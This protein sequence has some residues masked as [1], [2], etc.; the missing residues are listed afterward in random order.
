MPHIDFPDVEAD[1]AGKDDED[2]G[3]PEDEP[4][5]VPSDFSTSERKDLGLEALAVFERR[6]RLGH[7]YDLLNAVKMSVNHQ[8][9]VRR[10]R[11]DASAGWLVQ[12][13]PRPSARLVH[14]AT[15][16]ILKPIN[17]EQ[18]LKSKNWRKPRE[19]GD[20]R[21]EQ[22]W[23]WT[24]IPPWTS[25]TDADAWQLE[26]VPSS[27]DLARINEEINKLHAE[28]KRTILG[29]KNLSLAWE[30]AALKTQ[31]SDGSRAY[32]RKK[33]D[34]FQKLSDQCS[35]TFAK[36]RRDPERSGITPILR[37]WGFGDP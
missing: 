25:K 1:E 34:M 24:A 37:K 8:A 15:S 10:R 9:G 23:I 3:S 2:C 21:E 19:Q 13:Q 12:L 14:T 36:A 31:L 30:S 4:L 11:T 29:F 5:V 35:E 22:S 27:A 33:A 17:M 18:D 6:I 28:F 7:A 20:S 32:A 26:V 16:D